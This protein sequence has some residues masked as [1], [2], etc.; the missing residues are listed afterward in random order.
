MCAGVGISADSFWKGAASNWGWSLSSSGN[1]RKSEMP[2]PWNICWED[3]QRHPK[4]ET[5]CTTMSK[6]LA[7]APQP[8]WNLYQNTTRSRSWHVTKGFNACL[9]EFWSCTCPVLPCCSHIPPVWNDTV[10]LL[11]DSVYNFFLLLLFDLL[12][13]S[14]KGSFF[15]PFFFFFFWLLR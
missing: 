15:L 9:S 5:M 7:W 1:L 10:C 4:R 11:W 12:F 8:H 14:F 3:E 2:R 13:V 6:A